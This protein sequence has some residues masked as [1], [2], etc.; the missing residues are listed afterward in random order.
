MNNSN[1][2]DS[3]KKEINNIFSCIFLHENFFK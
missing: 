2:Y 1:S 3:L